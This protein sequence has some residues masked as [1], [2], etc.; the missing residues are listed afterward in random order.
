MGKIEYRQASMTWDPRFSSFHNCSRCG[1]SPSRTEP[2][3]RA[4][5]RTRRR[6]LAEVVVEALEGI[7][8]EGQAHLRRLLDRGS[9]SASLLDGLRLEHRRVVGL[10]D[11]VGGEVGGVN[12]GSQARLERSSDAAQAVELDTAEEGVSL[13]LVRARTAETVLRVADQ[14]RTWS[15]LVNPW[16]RETHLRIRFSASTP[17]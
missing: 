12:G 8:D 7:S 1:L 13:D 9:A 14:A 10:V 2:L 15:V 17:S 3:R 16:T 4:A 5:S 11:L 6:P